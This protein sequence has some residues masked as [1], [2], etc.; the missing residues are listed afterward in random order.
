MSRSVYEI[1]KTKAFTLAKTIVVK[2]DESA[3]EMNNYMQTTQGISVN[4]NDRWTWRYY[5]NMA[6]EYHQADHLDLAQING[7][8]VGYMTVRIAGPDGPQDV[9]FT[10]DLLHGENAD[11]ALA[12]EFTYDSRPYKD[13]LERYPKFESLI[14]G[15]LNPV[16]IDT[17]VLAPDHSVLYCGDYF[18]EPYN[19]DYSQLIYRILEERIT[20]TSGLIESQET[21][22]IPR[23]QEYISNTIFRWNTNEYCAVD[24]LYWATLLANVYAYL[25]IKIL[26]IRLDNCMTEMAHS[27]HITEYLESHGRLGRHVAN[28]PLAQALY[29]YRN[30]VY[31]TKNY[32]KETTFDTLVDKMLT[33]N[34]VPIAGYSAVHDTAE[35]P[36]NLYPNAE[37]A[38]E[39]INF[40][41]VGSSR[42][43][44]T[45]QYVMEKEVPLARDNSRYL[46][47][48][49]TETRHIVKRGRFNDLKSKVLESS[50]MD[51][52]NTERY[53]L[54]DTLFNNWIYAACN[55]H[56]SGAIYINHPFTGERIQLTPLNALILFYYAA[57]VGLRDKVPTEIPKLWARWIPILTDS[58]PEQDNLLPYPTFNRLRAMTSVQRVS[59]AQLNKLFHHPTPIMQYNSTKAFYREVTKI[60]NEL[61]RKQKLLYITEDLHARPQLEICMRQFYWIDVECNPNVRDEDYATWLS[62]QGISFEGLD[63]DDWIGM[64]LDIVVRATGM[65]TVTRKSL[66]D[67]QQSLLDIMRH[68]S[69][70][71]VQYLKGIT[72]GS[73][74][75]TDGKIIRLSDSGYD[76]GISADL[77]GPLELAEIGGE[78]AVQPLIGE[79]I[80]IRDGA[81]LY[82]PMMDEG[83]FSMSI[84]GSIGFHKLN[85]TPLV[86]LTIHNDV[87]MSRLNIN[88]LTINILEGPPE[89]RYLTSKPYPLYTVEALT[90]FSDGLT[91]VGNPVITNPFRTYGLGTEGVVSAGDVI[92]PIREFPLTVLDYGSDDI[93]NNFTDISGEYRISAMNTTVDVVNPISR[94]PL[95]VRD[96]DGEQ[97]EWSADVGNLIGRPALIV[98]TVNFESMSTSGDVTNPERK[99]AY[100]EVTYVHTEGVETVGD[101]GN[102]ITEGTLRE[103]TNLEGEYLA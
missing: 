28:L 30:V 50:M 70:Y 79:F 11:Y 6:G 34:R 49:I 26:N 80:D 10:K 65:D 9:L 93:V 95:I 41:Q 71:T 3:I 20:A 53:T 45:V 42:D 31:H 67:M 39:S 33:P 99:N 102:V 23:I 36:G 7:N 82:D 81:D 35:M 78:F 32:G 48:R 89:F 38:R 2:H 94:F 15:I 16:N 55:G 57:E 12:N 97:F 96:I 17:A 52:T 5:L 51:Y 101:V 37:M 29:L 69:S 68:F 8:G 21:N 40:A 43:L 98:T 84:G 83:G 85:V 74:K 91:S 58:V 87:P 13:L 77:G 66:A 24:N 76:R 59:D 103:P 73:P 46:E 47:E 92:N 18:A 60:W 64:A 90:V 56:Y 75:N 4:E 54:P 62:R 86:H 27:Y 14:L 44:R 19:D 1:F 25:P 61:M 72:F 63:A 88:N 22:L 100:K